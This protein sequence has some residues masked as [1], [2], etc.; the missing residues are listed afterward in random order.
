MLGRIQYTT[1][2]F[3][4]PDATGSLRSLAISVN[5]IRK[6]VTTR[7][8]LWSQL[9]SSFKPGI[10]EMNKLNTVCV[11]VY[12]CVCFC[13]CLQIYY[14]PKLLLTAVKIKLNVGKT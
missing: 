6:F 10:R 12:V 13:V 5:H 9:A 11:C 4:I 2:P 8:A 3:K 7:K 1:V 14:N